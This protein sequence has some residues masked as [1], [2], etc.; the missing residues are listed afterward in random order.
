M[1][2][3]SP[4]TSLPPVIKTSV[5]YFRWHSPAAA[6]LLVADG[7]PGHGEHS[8]GSQEVCGLKEGKVL[9]TMRLAVQM[10]CTIQG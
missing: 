7:A 9:S 3:H 4:E 1:H 8:E 6:S 5:S 10:Q 2:S